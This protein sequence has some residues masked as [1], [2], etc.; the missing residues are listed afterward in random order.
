MP[1]LF[2]EDAVEHLKDTIP[3]IRRN[4]WVVKERSTIAADG[5]TQDQSAAI[6]LYTMEWKL[7]DQSFYIHINNA[8]REIDRE[9]IV[10]FLLSNACSHCSMETSISQKGCTR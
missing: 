1:L 2:L 4:A 10:P 5:L 7:G 3:N 9:K 6:Q 8:L